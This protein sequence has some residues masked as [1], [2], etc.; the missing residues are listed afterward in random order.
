MILLW[1]SEGTDYCTVWNCYYFLIYTMSAPTVHGLQLLLEF[2]VE[3]DHC[4]V[5][6][7]LLFSDSHRVCT[8][9][10]LI[11]HGVPHVNFRYSNSSK[12]RCTEG[13]LNGA[14]HPMCTQ[15]DKPALSLNQEWYSGSHCSDWNSSSKLGQS[16]Q[17]SYI[18]SFPL[19][20]VSRA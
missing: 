16:S 20:V 14:Q 13:Y 5:S 6:A 9:C 1:H 18:Y 17:L 3:T 11:L 4:T 8:G 12:T 15:Y 2:S 10:V 19:V 7:L